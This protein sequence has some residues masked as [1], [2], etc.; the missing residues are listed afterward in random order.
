ME[1][2][3]KVLDQF[4]AAD[5]RYDSPCYAVQQSPSSVEIQDQH[6]TEHYPLNL[7]STEKQS[8]RMRTR[9]VIITDKS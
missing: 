2:C 7:S 1:L 8:I 9:C 6:S 3:P 4:S 5:L